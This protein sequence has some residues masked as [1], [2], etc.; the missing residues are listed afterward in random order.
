MLPRLHRVSPMALGHVPLLHC[1]P[2]NCRRRADADDGKREQ[3]SPHSCSSFFPGIDPP[4]R[5]RPDGPVLPEPV[6]IKTSGAEIQWGSA[7]LLRGDS[8]PPLIAPKP[9]PFSRDLARAEAECR[10]AVDQEPGVSIDRYSE[11]SVNT[12][13]AT[14]AGGRQARCGA[15]PRSNARRRQLHVRLDDFWPKRPAEPGIAAPSE[16]DFRPRTG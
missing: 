13:D 1:A 15:R 10:A 12:Q 8:C 4:C 2:G 7:R 9:E 11:V 3:H 5:R 16:A 14:T 6:L